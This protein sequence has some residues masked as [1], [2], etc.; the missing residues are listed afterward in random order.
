MGKYEVNVKH[1][2]C[3]TLPECI[4]FRPLEVKDLHEITQPTDIGLAPVLE[5]V[6]LMLLR[7]YIIW[8]WLSLLETSYRK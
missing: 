3:C 8:H 1:F 2:P 6:Q 7:R 4:E 5:A